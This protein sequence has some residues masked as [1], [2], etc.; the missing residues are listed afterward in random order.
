MYAELRSE[1]ETEGANITHHDTAH[2]FNTWTV[3]PRKEHHRS[4]LLTKR[5]SEL[6][7]AQGIKQRCLTY[8]RKTRAGLF[9]F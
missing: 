2:H 4:A 6:P 1:R 3:F 8:F 7:T 9:P 5:G